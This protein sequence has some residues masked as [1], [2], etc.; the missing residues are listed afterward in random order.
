MQCG[1]PVH[2]DLKRLPEKKK[3]FWENW[4]SFNNDSRL[5]DIKDLLIIFIR[6]IMG[7]LLCFLKSVYISQRVILKHLRL[8]WHGIWE[9]LLSGLDYLKINENRLVKC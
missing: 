6:V 4:K 2:S 8:K 9:M 1:P 5:N 7:L 3:D